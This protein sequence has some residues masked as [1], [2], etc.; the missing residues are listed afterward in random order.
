MGNVNEIKNF[1]DL[2]AWKKGHELVLDIYNITKNFPKDELYGMVSQLRRAA[3]SKTANIA[4]GFARYH[5][6]DKARFYYQSRGS[7]AEV[8]NFLLLAKD[9]NFIDL[10]TCKNL[11]RNAN[12]VGRIINSLIKSIEA[13]NNK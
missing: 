13:Q 4:E 8:Q 10:E 3:S 6:K 9:L 12:E 7:V 11:G 2:E 5:F 1:D